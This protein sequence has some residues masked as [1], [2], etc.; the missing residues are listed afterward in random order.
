[1]FRVLDENV[2]V[3]SNDFVGITSGSAVTQ[4]YRPNRGFIPNEELKWTNSNVRVK[5]SFCGSN[6]HDDSRGN[7]K[8][9]GAPQL[10]E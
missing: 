3:L 1:M 4:L 2:N 5:C 7:C 10:G 6:W 8:S 9:C